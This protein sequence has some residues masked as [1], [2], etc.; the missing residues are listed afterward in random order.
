MSTHANRSTHGTDDEVRARRACVVLLGG[1]AR[2]LPRS[3]QTPTPYKDI[4][5]NGPL[6]HVYVGNDTSCQ[7]AHTGDA[8]LRGLPVRRHPRQLRNLRGQG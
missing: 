8:A 7:V 6:T 2:R 1:T 3:A 4:A 5:S